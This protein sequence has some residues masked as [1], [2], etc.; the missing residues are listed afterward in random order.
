[1]LKSMLKPD[2]YTDVR[3]SVVGISAEILSQLK[4]EPSQKYNGLQSKVIYKLGNSAKKNFLFA[5]M[6][7]FSVGKI[8]YH[9]NGDAIELLQTENQQ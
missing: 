6:F 5:L 8:K 3:L 7:L 9:K 4:K 2:K 1:M